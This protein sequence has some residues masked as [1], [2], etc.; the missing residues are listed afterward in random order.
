MDEELSNLISALGDDD[1]VA[2]LKSLLESSKAGSKSGDCRKEKEEIE[3]LRRKLAE[4]ERELERTKKFVGELVRQIPKPAFV[5]FLNKDGVIEYINEYA[6]E[7]YGAELSEMIG[8]RPSD[9]ASNVAAG[10]KT[11]VELAFEKKMKIEGKEGFLEVKTGKAMPILTSCAPVYV[12]GEFAGMVDFFIDI[13]EQKRREEETKKAY[14]L[15]R[16]VFKNLPTY[17]IFV[18]EDGLIKFANNNVARLAGFENADEVIGLKPAEVAVIHKDYYDNAKK[19]VEAIK[20]RDRIENVEVKLVGKGGKEFV[21]STSIY[22]VYVGD[23]FA[24]YI[25]V[26]YDITEL[27]EKEREM[28]GLV[29]STP[30]AVM[31]IDSNHNVVYWNKAA[32]EL[33][34]VKAEEVVGTNRTWYPFYDQER[35]VLADLVLDNP[36]EA[37]KLYDVIKRHPVIEGAFLTEMW[38]NF[39][40]K[41][42]KAYVRATAAPVYDENGGVIGVVESIEDLT[43]IKEKE[44]EVEEMLAYTSKCLHMLSNGIRELQA[45]NLG[46]RLEKPKDD[47]FGETFDAFN[48]FAERLQEIV[49]KLAED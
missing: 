44:R 7:I 47:E 2:R 16:E 3:E 28:K 30:V 21:A 36:H 18:G 34:G 25:E 15:V 17:V 26:F 19:I 49:R 42:K 23:S 20:K 35:P 31:Y 10:G 45:G 39:P 6:A 38:L 11:F 24:G 41:G 43:A 33:T 14:E 9:L 5:L 22:P 29:D 8:K 37:H 32:E 40:R 12:D 46:V 27:K 1:A 48:E 4:T 13:T